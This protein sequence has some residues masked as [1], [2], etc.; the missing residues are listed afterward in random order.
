MKSI[1]VLGSTGSIGKSTLSVARHLS[2]EIRVVALAAHSNI[3]LLQ[4]QV[5]EFH[6]E[7]VAVYDEKKGREL[8]KLLPASVQV[9]YGQQGV[10][11]V[12]SFPTVD[13]VV[14]AMVGMCALSPTLKA[15]ESGKGIG[16]ANKEVLVSAGDLITSLARRKNVLVLPIDS[17]HNAIFQ[18]LQ[19][20]KKEEILRIILTAS[21]GP[22]RSYTRE[23][24][25]KVTLDEALL[26]PTWKM[27]PKITIDSSTLMN[28]GLEMIEAH[29][30]FQIPSEQIEVVIHPQ[31]I[32]HSMVECVDGS[33]FAEMSEPNMAYPIQ[34]A[35]TYPQRKKG[36]FPP[37]NFLKNSRLEFFSPDCEKFPSLQFAYEAVKKGGSLPCFLNAANEVLVDRFLRKEIS[38]MGIMHKL[39]KLISQHSITPSESIEEV[40]SIDKEAREKAVIA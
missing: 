34:Y 15:I 12:A 6:P 30:L 26:H 33:V 23:Q 29:Y 38:W 21:G 20:K 2:Q 10:E 25:E 40:F 22:F 5:E 27:G 14:V 3:T 16:L 17:E 28:K 31:S 11:E 36:M 13:F 39:E 4:E 24:L 9:V 1:A 19:G 32:I 18:C 7:I 8:K 37:F 35:L